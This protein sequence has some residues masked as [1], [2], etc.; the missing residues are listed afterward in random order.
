MAPF[1]TLLFEPV[2]EL[3]VSRV[4]RER[5]Q[6][7]EA[8]FASDG[9]L[10]FG[11]YNAVRLLAHKLNEGRSPG[12]HINPGQINAAGVLEEVFHFIFRAYEAKHGTK[13]FEKAREWL[14]RRL[15]ADGVQQ[16]LL[17]FIHG[18]PPTEVFKGNESA[19][20]YLKGNR[21]SRSLFSV[22]TEEALLLSLSEL[23]PANHKLKELFDIR[24]LRD[25]SLYRK[26]IT[27]LEA[28]F[29]KQPGFGPGNQNV[30]AFLKTPMMLEPENI[31]AQLDYVLTHWKP[32]LPA[33][34]TEWILKG[35][36]LLRED[37]HMEAGG[38]PGPTLVPHY[39]GQAGPGGPTIGKSGFPFAEEAARS[40]EEYEHFTPDTHWMPRVVLL[41]KNAYVWLD[42]LT[43]KYG[44]EIK[45]LG[46]IPD[47]E[48]DTIASRGFNGLWLI[49]VWERSTASK[50]IKHLMGNIDAVSSA[51]SLYDYEIAG[52]LGGEAAFDN[53]NQRAKDRGIRLASDMVPNHT[54]LFSRWVIDHPDYFIQTRTPP[55]PAYRFTGENLSTH[56]DIEIRIEDGY[57]SKTDAAVVFQRI[58]KRHND[59]RYIYHGNDGTNMP[60]NDTAQL[61]MLRKEVREAVMSKI[62]EVARR[63][64]IIRFDA[65]MTL[66]KKHF[67]RLWYP[68]P[69]SGGDIPSRSDHAMSQKAF[70]AL[71]PVE[72]WR[73]VVDRMNREMP[74][75][76]LLAEAFWLMEGYFVRTLGMHRV[77]NSAFMHMMKNEENEKYRDLIS[78]TLEFEPEILKRY[79]NFMSNPD[80]ETAIRQFGTDDKYFGVCVMM[81]TLPGLPMFAHGQVEGFTEKY[82][83]EY[84]RAYYNET[85]DQWLEDRHQ[86]EVFPLLGKRFLFSEVDHFNLFDF[87]DRHGRVNENVFA[88][89]NR[90]GEES[91]L[92]LFNNKYEAADGALRVSTPKLAKGGDKQ[93]I[94]V[95]LGDALGVKNDD[96]AYYL[97]REQVSGLEFIRKGSE[98]HKNGF[99]WGLRGFEY[100]VFL[101]FR[102]DTRS[103]GVL[104]EL[105]RRLGGQGTP[106]IRREMDQIRFKDVYESFKRIFDQPDINQ[107]SLAS[108]EKN[109]GKFAGSACRELSPCSNTAP[110]V[111]AFSQSLRSLLSTREYLYEIKRKHPRATP[112]ANTEAFLP[113]ENLILGAGPENTSILLATY[114]ITALQKL[115]NDPEETEDATAALML[116]W[117]LEQ[118]LKKTGKGKA[119]ITRDILLIRILAAYGSRVFDF[120][121]NALKQP[122][123]AA[124]K[125]RSQRTAV[126]INS[127]GERIELALVDD[128]LVQEFLGVNKYQGVV[129]Y[130]K[131]SFEELNLW[132]FVMGLT[133]YFCEPGLRE[134]CG[135]KCLE[136]AVALSQKHFEH[137]AGLSQQANYQLE[138]LRSFLSGNG[139]VGR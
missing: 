122:K 13:V 121:E 37:L 4:V 114:A 65:A 124:A 103:E 120:S 61:D 64:S 76:L 92:V 101:D 128:P 44:R 59:L 2:W 98:F 34:L 97:F 104:E 62:M 16:L 111:E 130:S 57:Y 117:P 28:F 109:F 93:T 8:L 135:K 91:A 26:F 21:E 115:K 73:E 133:G 66:A 22:T 83:M 29:M 43:K 116:H 90:H 45:T 23:N 79:V 86:R 95:N 105:H 81:A 99:R 106:D 33:S 54:G 3:H 107:K 53:L 137:L 51:Y 27:E 89:T 39:K 113:A 56:P 118:I 100:R 77:Y 129:Y 110:A 132:L 71:F 68:K 138:A 80:E 38:G 78:N 96:Q 63:F 102:P 55:F 49:G 139:N 131:E 10:V 20:S 125:T 72:F 41:A 9:R 60:W 85:P 94:S 31:D 48:L 50:R 5:Y 46:Q 17:D 119:E 35:K 136:T 75:T 74:D 84:Q 40:Y 123:R 36:D 70:D 127:P 24:V 67:S 19:L 47:Q 87:I 52:D 88:F 18:F 108:L 7:D 112:D 1:S 58:D 12:K 69:G 42:Q 82:G 30:I 32:W 15:G 25:H 134:N 14:E 6:L 11:N 126:Q